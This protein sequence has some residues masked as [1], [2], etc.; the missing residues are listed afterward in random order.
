MWEGSLEI[1]DNNT[2]IKK[3]PEIFGTLEILC[4]KMQYYFFLGAAF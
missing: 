4:F 2:G 1:M 3:S